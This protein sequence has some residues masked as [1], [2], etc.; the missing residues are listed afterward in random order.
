MGSCLVWRTSSQD[1]RVLLA[2]L[3]EMR[4]RGMNATWKLTHLSSDLCD[5]VLR[6][7]VKAWNF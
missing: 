3:S 2:R 4:Q 1:V 6:V 7:K 5:L